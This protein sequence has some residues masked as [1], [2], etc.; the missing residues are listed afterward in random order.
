MLLKGKKVIVTSGATQ[1]PLDNVRYLTNISRGSFGAMIAD[2]VMIQQAD[3]YYLHGKHAVM[4]H[5]AHSMKTIEVRTTDDLL[6]ELKRLLTKGDA[7]IVIHALAV[8]DY[9][10]SDIFNAEGRALK[11]EK[12]H[13]GQDLTLHLKPTPNI[14]PHIKEWRKDVFLAGF[15]LEPVESEED[16]IE[17]GKKSLV[18]NNM[19]LAVVRRL[20]R[21]KR[22]DHEAIFVNTRGEV[23]R[24]FGK[25]S[26]AKKL[27]RTIYYELN[28]AEKPVRKGTEAAPS[29]A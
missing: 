10:I 22:E 6:R 16:L 23:E 5:F 24:H 29:Q 20:H 26:I 11:G 3:V 19:D 27:V 8:S 13:A 1:E 2:E 25:S 7:S 28:P 15:E 17:I 12:I 4:P 18:K 9:A 14:I 21:I